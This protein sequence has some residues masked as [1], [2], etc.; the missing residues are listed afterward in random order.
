MTEFIERTS[1]LGAATASTF[2]ISSFAEDA[3][4]ELYILTNRNS[5]HIFKIEP[6]PSVLGAPMTVARS[7]L[8]LSPPLPN[9]SDG[10]FVTWVSALIPAASSSRFTT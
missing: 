8:F 2:R 1:E 4:G 9:P 5:G 10:R 7:P 3:K 6:D